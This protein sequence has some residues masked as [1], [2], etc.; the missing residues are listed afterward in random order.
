M[1]WDV[2]VLSECWLPSSKFIPDLDGF[3]Y[4][5][6]TANRTQNEGVVIYYN[7]FLDISYEEPRVSDANCILLKINSDT[8]VLGIYRP[9][10]ETNTTNF[11]NSLDMLLTKLRKFRNT[12]LCGDVNID[13]IEATKDKRSFEYLNILASH[14]LLPAHDLPTHGLTCL[15]HMMLKTKLDATCFVV[16]SS[17]TDHE[18]V[19]LTL[20]TLTKFEYSNKPSSSAKGSSINEINHYFANI[21]KKLAETLDNTNLN[22]EPNLLPNGETPPCKSFILLPTDELEVNNLIMG[23]KNRCAVGVDQISGTII[24]RYIHFLTK[25]ITHICNLA[26][27]SGEFPNA[28]KIAL[29]KPIHKGG[30][31]EMTQ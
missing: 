15:D 1:N 8:C 30:I 21:G 4:I 7:K 5:H 23:L 11:V 17:I 27:S 28:F 24:K 6:T 13:I 12:I 31:V 10:S 25:P 18:C 2:I 29:I 22:S 14:S 26:F 19:A 9:P 16:E 20:V 3:N